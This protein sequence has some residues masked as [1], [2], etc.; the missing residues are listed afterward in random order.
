MALPPL[1]F[2]P[3]FHIVRISHVEW[4]VTDID[5]AKKFYVDTLGYHLEHD[6]GEA[7]YLRGF[8]ELNHHSLIL[9]SDSTAYVKRIGYKV[10]SEVDL[11][12][13][14][15]FF[16]SLG[17]PTDWVDKFAQGRS[18][19]TSDPFG[20]PLE[21]YFEMER[22]ESLLQQ[23]GLHRGAHIQRLDHANLFHHDVNEATRFYVSE[24]GFRPTE[25]TVEDINDRDSNLWAT[26]LQRRG[27]VH[28]VAFTNGRGPRLHHIG[29]Y[30]PT[31]TDIINF[32]DVLATTGYLASFERGPGR[33]GIANAFF[34]YI[35]DTDG[36]RIELFSSDYLTVD[37]DHPAKLWDLRDPQRQTLWGQAAPR[38]WFEDG[39]TFE[40]LEPSES[41]LSREPIIAPD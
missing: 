35:R 24:L 2:S 16:R 27:S 22:G 33:H 38:S 10:A 23:Y 36:H 26:W 7:L 29:V 15:A 12:K 8:E 19:H 20:V 34:L 32:C 25:V 18:L 14:E 31:A 17:Q 11:V 37:P 3:P 9:V 21:F 28:D 1:N 5:A 4:T 39:M 40:G 13:A 30:V 6:S 41:R